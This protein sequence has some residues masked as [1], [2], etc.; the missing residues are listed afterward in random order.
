MQ[1]QAIATG[2]SDLELYGTILSDSSI[3][4]IS[5]SVVSGFVVVGGVAEIDLVVTSIAALNQGCSMYAN[6]TY[7]NG[8]DYYYPVEVTIDNLGT[9]TASSFYLRLEVYWI[10]GSLSEASRELFIAT[11]TPETGG[12]VVNFTDTFHPAHT[13]FYRLTAT[14]DSRNNITENN[15]GNNVRLL[16]DVPVAV[17]GDANGD[18]QVNIL[19]GVIL[20]LAWSATPSDPYWNIKAD[21]NHDGAINILDG[22]RASVHWTETW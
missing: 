15:E 14:V 12:L 2:T 11:L 7:M 21:L 10:N 5:H 22:V 6:D 3:N 16:D 9:A 19:D 18:R 13:G 17:M 4:P 8:S 20:S 1:F